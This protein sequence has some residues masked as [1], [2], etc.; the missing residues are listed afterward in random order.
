MFYLRSVGA[1]DLLT[2]KIFYRSAV[3]QVTKSCCELNRIK[4]QW[5]AITANM[6]RKNAK[7]MTK[8]YVV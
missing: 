2:I 3:Q 7:S 1:S 5:N 6:E 8:A 4:N